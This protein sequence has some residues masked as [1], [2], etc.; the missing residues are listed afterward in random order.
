MF[1]RA[2][3]CAHHSFITLLAGNC[4]N[5]QESGATAWLR[6]LRRRLWQAPHCRLYYCTGCLII[7]VPN[8][9]EEHDGWLLS[10][11]CCCWTLV[12]H[13]GRDV[14]RSG[15]YVV[16]VRAVFLWPSV[17]TLAIVQGCGRSGARR[18]LFAACNAGPWRALHV[19]MLWSSCSLLL[20]WWWESERDA[21]S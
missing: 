8:I 16:D 2:H 1:A 14:R 20:L 4:R 19:L 15:G 21:L 6:F 18:G 13:F 5:L 7:I 10:E 17:L 11:C 3:A 12:A 9:G